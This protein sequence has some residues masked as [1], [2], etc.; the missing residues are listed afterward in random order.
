MDPLRILHVTPYWSDAWAYG[1]IPRVVGAQTRALAGRGH[2][3]VVCATDA[4]SAT[5]RLQPSTGVA[6]GAPWRIGVEAGLEL[7][8]FPN[9][10]NRLAFDWQ[11]YT[12]MG[13]ASYL[14]DHAASFDVAHLHACRNWPVAV[15]AAQLARHGVPFVLGP[16]GTAPLIERRQW[17][18]RIFD[19]VAGRRMMSQAAAVLA[20]SEAERRQIIELGVAPERIHLVPNPVDLDEFTPPIE[21]GRFRSSAG[22]GAGP[23]VA[24]LGKITPRKRVDLLVRAFADQDQSVQLVLAG[25]D[26]GGLQQALALA[27][28]LGVRS[29][30]H[31][32]GVLAGRARLE[33][34]A[35]ADVVVYP[36]EHEIFGLVPVEA[37]LVGTPVVVADDSGCG[38]VIAKTGGGLIVP[39]GHAAALTTAIRHVLAA[40]RNWREAAQAAGAVVRS[41]YDAERLVATL[42]HV[43]EHVLPV[44]LPSRSGVSFVVPVRNGGQTLA[45]VIAGIDAQ[46]DGRPF[47]ILAIDDGS[48]DA[49]AAWLAEEQRRGRLRLIDG[50]RRGVAAALNAG[51]AMAR[52]PIIC[53]VDQDVEL[54]A[55]WLAHLTRE[56]DRDPNLGAVEGHYALDRRAPT[57]ARV[58]SLD[59]EQRYTSAVGREATH[60]CT[61]N[62]AYRASALARIGPFDERFGYGADN[63][64]SYRLRQA[65]YRLA[66]CARAR[67]VHHWRATFAGFCRQQ[68]GF[69]Y[70][71]LDVVARH[72]GQVA[73]DSVAPAL[74]MAHPLLLLVALACAVWAL[75]AWVAG[76]D[77]ALPLTMSVGLV[78]VLTGERALAGTRAAWRFRDPAALLFP[79]AHLL[80]DLCWIAAVGVWCV[81]RLAGRASYPAHSMSPRPATRPAASPAGPSSWPWRVAAVIP[82]H[83][84]A[85]SVSGVVADLRRVCPALDVVVIDD[86]S[87]DGT[88]HVLE[89]E[90]VRHVRL[91]E[92]MGVGSAVRAGLRYARRHGFD[93]VIRLDGDGQHAASDVALLLAPLTTGEDDVVFGSRYLTSVERRGLLPGAVQAVLAR[94]LTMMTKHTV[95]D[96]T[97]G[98]C[99][100]G[101]RALTLLSDHHPTGYPEAELR[102]LLARNRLSVVEVAVGSHARRAGRTS[103]TASRL[104]TAGARVLLALLIVPFRRV[105]TGAD[106]D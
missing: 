76:Q 80:R 99:A 4:C 87:T 45:A 14:R 106:A 12:P 17:A 55:G 69:G 61:G 96:P 82:V 104:A 84:E 39:A 62:T 1:G 33:L 94:C 3:V 92:R 105:V 8:V 46:R 56:L 10:S 70:G 63:D 101:P 47:E 40:P 85:Q 93:A 42:E 50:P 58:M 102:L 31:V 41:E 83:N 18:K 60:V 13:F 29:R 67:S 53:Q 5:T 20:V 6:H 44:T 27:N 86:G 28:S 78:A 73:G 11:V 43:Y 79:A 9:R 72:P 95:T 35:D 75:V 89:L 19:V 103:L 68:Y 51:V 25:S 100:I 23:L 49:S 7:R 36:T 81:R 66:H 16:N 2:D 71:R 74:M 97:S 65:G 64:M 15:A 22:L 90:G 48:E 91:P 77:V 24:F 88:D 21:R 30:V 52:H 26:M 54:G 32:E 34:L 98:F 37:L 57:L 59:L 38:E